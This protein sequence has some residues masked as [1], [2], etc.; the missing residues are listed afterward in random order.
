[1]DFVV[2]ADHRVK[3]KE[4]EKKVKYLDLTCEL[5]K[6]WNVNV[7]VIPIVIGALGSVTNGLVQ[8]LEDL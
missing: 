4:N 1:M 3:I 8:G 6:Q 2:P 5:K 7:S